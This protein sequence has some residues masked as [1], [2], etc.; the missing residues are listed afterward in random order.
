[1]LDEIIREASQI[2]KKS[3]ENLRKLEKMSK[4]ITQHVQTSKL[5]VIFKQN[6]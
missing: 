4:I 1:M 5:S 2:L 3:D 6:E